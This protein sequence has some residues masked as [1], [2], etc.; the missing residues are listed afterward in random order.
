M[1]ENISFK[2]ADPAKP[3][4]LV[5]V[6]INGQGP[7][8]FILDTGA[9]GTMV[10][11]ELAE[12]LGIEEGE[13]QEARGAGGGLQVTV[14]RVDTFS[15]GASEQEDVQVAL[16]DMA[17]LSKNCG[18][19]KLAGIVGF[20]YLKNYTVTIRYPDNTLYLE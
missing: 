11:K 10:S 9:S 14:S 19:D 20:N 18:I 1:P 12:K 7:Y 4:L 8:D 5:P 15:V 13:S 17:E 16:L 3:L 6:F 2:I